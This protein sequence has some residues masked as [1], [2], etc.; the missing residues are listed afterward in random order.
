MTLPDWQNVGVALVSGP[1][2]IAA[3]KWITERKSKK[4]AEIYAEKRGWSEDTAKVRIAE[5]GIVPDL[6]KLHE[7]REAARDKRMEMLETEMRS[8]RDRMEREAIRMQNYIVQMHSDY[9]RAV[10]RADYADAVLSNLKQDWKPH[11][12]VRHDEIPSFLDPPAHL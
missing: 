12:L 7:A 11:S 10:M 6:M 8:Q 2:S 1:L 9:Q 5:L 3:F 4:E